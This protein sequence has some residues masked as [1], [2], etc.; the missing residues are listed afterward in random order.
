[1]IYT[2]KPQG[3]IENIQVVACYLEHDGKILLLQRQPNKTH[4]GRWG[5]P[6]GKID[7]R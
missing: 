3:F 1:M 5:L 4:G 2:N 6:A 7:N